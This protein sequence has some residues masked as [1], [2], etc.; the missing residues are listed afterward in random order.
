MKKSILI[1]AFLGFAM[2]AMA[3]TNS[4]TRYQNGYFK[5]D[6]TYVPGH[7]KTTAN[8]TNHDNLSTTPN[9]NYFTGENGSRAR[10]YSPQ[11]QNYGQGRVIHTGP[12]GGQYYYNDKG[13]K[14]YVPKQ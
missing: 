3:Q 12:K 5:S 1:L 11:A 4:S 14:V 8:T 10:D 9:T 2:A 7:F 13:N 6:G